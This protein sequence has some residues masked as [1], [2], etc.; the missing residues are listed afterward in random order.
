MT[1]TTDGQ[2]IVILA[3][4]VTEMGGAQRIVHVLAAGLA[5]RGHTVQVVGIVP[6]LPG[7]DWG[8]KGY[9]VITLADDKQPPRA[10]KGWRSRMPKARAATR[11]RT[12]VR[13]QATARL[14]KLLA[15]AEPG[16]VICAQVWAM[17]HLAEVPHDGWRVIG[18][19]HSSYEVAARGRD[20]A[21]VVASYR[22]VDTFAAL[23]MTD[24]RRFAAHGMSNATAIPNPLAFFP[25]QT[26]SPRARQITYLGRLAPE[27]GPAFLIEAWAQIARRHD[28][29][30]L[31]FVGGGPLESSMHAL[32]T[33]LDIA[34]RVRFEPAVADVQPVLMRTGVLALPSLVEGLPLAVAEAMACG[35]ACVASD[36]SDG[37]RLLVEDERT[38]LI[39][40]RGDAVHLAE[41][42][43]R[44][45]EDSPLRER[46]GAA[47]REHVRQFELDRILDRWEELFVDVLR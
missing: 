38:G 22:D 28:D 29:W 41:Q 21:R 31:V 13:A 4:N 6:E 2:R 39:A 36:C 11:K 32:A 40:R 3:N 19:Y 23:T 10:P 7:H 30:T 26:A 43:E 18:Q 16:I 1:P 45:I 35:V 44:L 27:K 15:S 14:T 37:V 46:L 12:R 24:A 9:D 8:A 34:H 25:A 5:G 47:A 17:E 42:L 20:L 33:R